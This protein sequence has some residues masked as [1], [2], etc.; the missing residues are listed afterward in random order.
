MNTDEIKNKISKLVGTTVIIKINLG[1]N[2]Y[3]TI[4][5]VVNNIYPYIFSI[6]TDNDIKTFSYVDIL[7]K[8]VTLISC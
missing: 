4:V 8:N 2:K 5:G 1:R 3:D 7:I 6:K